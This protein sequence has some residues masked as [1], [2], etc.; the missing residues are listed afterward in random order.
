MLHVMVIS[1]ALF[2]PTDFSDSLP[3]SIFNSLELFLLELH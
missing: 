2:F 3:N 1:G